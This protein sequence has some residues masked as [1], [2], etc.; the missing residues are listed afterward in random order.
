MSSTAVRKGPIGR[1]GSILQTFSFLASLSL[2]G[3]EVSSGP[4]PIFKNQL[5]ILSISD[6]SS[7]F[8]KKTLL[9]RRL[10]LPLSVLQERRW[11]LPYHL[12]HLDAVLRNPSL[13]SRG[14]H[15][16]VPRRRRND[17]CRK[18]LSSAQRQVT[19]NPTAA[20]RVVL[21]SHL[22]YICIQ[23]SELQLWLWLPTTTSII[24]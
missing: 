9:F 22:F 13:P 24:A 12:L 6:L 1:A 20:L 2:W 17:N 16:P 11:C 23:V 18:N 5:G 3:L 4:R 8:F 10:A 14:C 21:S 15:W 19:K 7:F